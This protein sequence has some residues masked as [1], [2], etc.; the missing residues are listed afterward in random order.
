MNKIDKICSEEICT[1]CQA[2]VHVCPSHAITFKENDKGFFYP[3][4]DQDR[5]IGCKKC[6]NICPSIDKRVEYQE[7][8]G[9]YAGWIKEEKNR[10]YSTSG[11][12]AF[13]LSKSVIEEGGGVCACRWNKDHAEHCFAENISEL[14]QFQGSK[15]AYSDVGDSY[16]RIK[17]Y[18]KDGRKILFV[19]TG[20][21]VA[22]LKSYLQKDYENLI[23]VDLLCHGIPSQ[24]AL[25][26]RIKHEESIKGDR[27]VDVRFRDKQED[28][29]HTCM[30]FTFSDGSNTY[31]PVYKDFFFRGFV[32]NHLLRPNCFLCQY[33]RRKRITDVTL[34][35]FWGYYP[36]NMGFLNYRTGVS[37][38]L[39]NT[40]RGKEALCKLKDFKIE[41]RNYIT[42]IRSN[43]NLSAPQ[44][45]PITYEEFWNRYESGVGLQVLAHD[46]FPG[47]SVPPIMK[48]KIKT[49]LI[50]LLGNVIGE[51]GILSLKQLCKNYLR[52]LYV[53][54]LKFAGKHKQDKSDWNKFLSF[55]ELPQGPKRVFYFG[56]TMH[57]NLGDL[58]Q[59]YCITKWI[60]E[61]YPEHELA[62]V[63]S[64]V[65]VNKNISKRFFE[66]LGKIYGDD[67][68]IVFQSGYCT[69]DLGGNHPLMHRLVC[70]YMPDAKI[71][72]MPQTIYFKHE[73][74][75]QV[76]AENH[77][78]ARNMLFLARDYVS[79]EQAKKMF[80]NIRVEA[81][82]DIVT[83][84]IGTKS[85]NHFRRGVCLCTRNDS[86]K[87][88]TDEELSKL[89]D[90]LL[91]DGIFVTRKDT[92]S[93]ASVNELISKLKLYID[94][95]IE[96]YSHFEVTITDRYHG[97]IFSLCAG[98]PVIIIKTNDHKVTTG[99]DWFKGIYDDYVYVATDLDDAYKKAKE[100]MSKKLS[101]QL[102]PYF[103]ENYYDKLKSKF[104][105]VQ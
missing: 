49:I 6:Q 99:A 64:D 56:V 66:H 72:M 43:R 67:D 51:N 27:V 102:S 57:R 90:D 80:T 59:R 87:F 2:C 41:Q 36:I 91:N 78:K 45:K 37:L 16:P 103:K 71:L 4:I 86:E 44:I 89:E 65:I 54:L 9:V 69:Q 74:N 61:N 63:E 85:Y 8:I 96:S 46:Y 47:T 62:L 50:A 19:G 21:Q 100:I 42:A 48:K 32:T 104:E 60:R 1:G 25:R 30:K 81:F 13:S 40:S 22:G 7:P 94:A 23:T 95:E 58:A 11:G 76:C 3:I 20:C 15:Y 70:E 17:E 75:R 24:R 73:H 39:A 14:R 68:V 12:A 10:H 82:P 97:T 38:C 55:A 18:L 53:P 28:L 5:C 33:A 26:E 79:F 98:T 29:L 31:Y 84:L 52:W 88:Y 105:S 35:D 92:Q 77:N 93:S 83:T 101:H 34:A